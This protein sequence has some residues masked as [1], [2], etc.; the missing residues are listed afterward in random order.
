MKPSRDCGDHNARLDAAKEVVSAA[1]KARFSTIPPMASDATKSCLLDALGVAMAGIRASGVKEV[2]DWVTQGSGRPESRLVGIGAR[3]PAPEAAL[4]NA[5]MGHALDYDDTYDKCGLHC[6]VPI[7]F[8]LLAFSEREGGVRGEEFLT[9]ATLGLDLSC[10]LSAARKLAMEETGWHISATCGI[11]GAALACAK[12]AGLTE[13]RMLHALGIAYSQAAGNI[14][15]VRD[16]A[17]VKR[18]QPGLAARGAILAVDL[19]RRGLTGPSNIFEGTYGFFNLYERGSYDRNEIVNDLG[20]RFMGQSISFKPYP[21][22]RCLHA[23]ID[24]V[25]SVVQRHLIRADDVHTVEVHVGRLAH[26]LLTERAAENGDPIMD[27]QFSIPYTVAR[28]IVTGSVRLNDFTLEAISDATTYSLMARVRAEPDPELDVERGDISGARVRI[29]TQDGRILFQ[30]VT[31]PRGH[32]DNPMSVRERRGKFHDCISFVDETFPREAIEQII[33]KV[34]HLEELV[35]TNELLGGLVINR[36]HC[37]GG[38][39]ANS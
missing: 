11:F 35:S 22:C 6:G 30:S 24:S 5:T 31:V 2:V 12:L 27:A 7:L 26:G 37:P 17:L 3:V 13:E 36:Q 19:A 39:R 32:P 10:R 29:E 16:G 38:K 33:E 21:C 9:A 20:K 1:S 14:Q 18:I 34:E 28:A 8:A 25:R 4:A 15:S 23:V